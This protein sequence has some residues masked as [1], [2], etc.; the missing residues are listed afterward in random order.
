M[1]FYKVNPK[2]PND[3]EWGYEHIVVTGSHPFWVERLEYGGE[4][5]DILA[6][7]RADELYDLVA[8]TNMFPMFKLRDGHLSQWANS[9]PVLK[10]TIQDVGIVYSCPDGEPF[11]EGVA[12]DFSQGC[13]ETLLDEKGAPKYVPMDIE[14]EDY[15]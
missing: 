1:S 12:L 10:T 2:N 15:I 11:Y 3:K 13:P 7:M 4:F 5:K 9:G 6:W 14:P 8:K